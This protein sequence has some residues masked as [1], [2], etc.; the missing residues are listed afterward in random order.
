MELI[1]FAKNHTSLETDFEVGRINPRARK[2]DKIKILT[3]DEV[4]VTITLSKKDYEGLKRVQSIQAQK[5]NDSSLSAAIS[6][7]IDSYLRKND[8]VQKAERNARK[9]EKPQRAARDEKPEDSKAIQLREDA[10]ASDLEK[11][12]HA[13]GKSVCTYRIAMKKRISLTT[14]QKHA[15]ISRDGGRCTFRDHEGKRCNSDRYLDTHHILEVQHGG[16]NDPENLAT[17]CAF[18]HDLVHQ[19]SLPIEGQINWIR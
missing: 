12:V 1:C 11:S 18:H 8:P 15:V 3:E 5:G 16:T 7:A 6:A 10:P 14:A 17:L 2:K 9:N 19:L 13:S 4:Q